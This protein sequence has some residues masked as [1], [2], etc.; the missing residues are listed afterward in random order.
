V[1]G[2]FVDVSAQHWRQAHE[3][4]AQCGF[5]H[6]QTTAGQVRFTNTEL[7]ELEAKIGQCRR[8]RAALELEISD[9]LAATVA[10]ASAAIKGGGEA[11]Q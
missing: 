10:K 4:A 8:A 2:Y 7:G 6:R 11:L 1:L 9:R 5:I 3:R